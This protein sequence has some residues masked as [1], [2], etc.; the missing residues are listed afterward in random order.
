LD[1]IPCFGDSLD[2]RI[3]GICGIIEFSHRLQQRILDVA[4]RLVVPDDGSDNHDD[5]GDLKDFVERD[6]KRDI[7]G[8]SICE[9]FITME[10]QFRTYKIEYLN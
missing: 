10:F 9:S 5:E 6:S 8:V 3:G 1:L 4:Q 2:L 7:Q